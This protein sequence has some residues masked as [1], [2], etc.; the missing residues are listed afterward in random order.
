MAAEI[1]TRED[2]AIFKTELFRELRELVNAPAIQP[3]K[4]LKSYEVRDLLGISP[5]TLQNMRI[6]GT[7]SFTKIGGLIFY[8]YDDILKLMEGTKKPVKR[9]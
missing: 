1:L 7:I 5:G 2:L 3:R 6:N 9:S 8:E 4:W